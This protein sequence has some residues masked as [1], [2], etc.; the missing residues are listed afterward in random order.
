MAL[1]KGNGRFTTFHTLQS[2]GVIHC[3]VVCS[4]YEK[5]VQNSELC[6]MQPRIPVACIH[7]AVPSRGLDLLLSPLLCTL[8]L[9]DILPFSSTHLLNQSSPLDSKLQFQEHHWQFSFC[10]LSSFSVE[11]SYL[12]S[13]KRNSCASSCSRLLIVWSNNSADSSMPVCG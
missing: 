12:T 10:C 3:S 4:T 8:P 2:E 5:K 13:A 6:K 1:G 9:D 7:G 11:L